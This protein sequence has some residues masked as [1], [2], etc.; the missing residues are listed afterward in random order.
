M[1]NPVFEISD[2]I[3]HKPCCTATDDGKRLEISELKK[4]RDCKNKGADQLGSGSF[5]FA[6]AKSRFPHDAVLLL[7]GF[8]ERFEIITTAVLIFKLLIYSYIHIFNLNRCLQ[9]AEC[10]ILSYLPCII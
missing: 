6:Y 1:K 7:L 5:V 4:K 9:F 2:Q 8:N 10:I 3:R